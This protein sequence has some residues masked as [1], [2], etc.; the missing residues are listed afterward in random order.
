[1]NTDLASLD[2]PGGRFVLHTAFGRAGEHGAGAIELI[3]AG[4]ERGTFRAHLFGADGRV[5]IHRLTHEGTTW[6][7]RCEH[8]RA[9]VNFDGE[10][11]TQDAVHEYAADGRTF[12]VVSRVVLRKVG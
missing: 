12:S 9:V 4:D 6:L 8:T 10:Y 5:T 1:V 2:A 7:Y 11:R 3:G